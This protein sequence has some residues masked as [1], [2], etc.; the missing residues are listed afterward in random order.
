[1]AAPLRPDLS[2][3]ATLRLGLFQGCLGCLAVIFSGLLNRIML[4]E[5]AFPGLLVGGALACEQFVA[6]SGCCSA[7]SPI[8]IPPGSRHRLP[9]ILL[10]AALC[11][12]PALSTAD[13]PVAR[14]SRR[15]RT[16]GMVLGIAA[17]AGLVRLYGLAVSMAT[18]PYLALVIDRTTESERP[19]AV[20]L[21]WCML[22]V[23][24]IVGA[25]AIRLTLRSLDGVTDP[26]VLEV[27][28][29]GFMA[30]VASLV[31]LLTLVATGGWRLPCQIAPTALRPGGRM[32]SAS[33]SPGL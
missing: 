8:P 6:P 26:A 21:V 24:I 33:V 30:S 5:L 13:L 16:D 7:T 17:I 18:T 15:E 2:L 32:P 31:V 28:L 1:M 14:C 27:T 12:R 3:P 4:S 29:F 22:T 25:I 23:G 19:R 10:G 9:Y 20:S 11:A